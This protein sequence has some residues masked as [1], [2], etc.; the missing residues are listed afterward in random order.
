MN[1][2]FYMPRPGKKGARLLATAVPM[3]RHESLEVF[4]DLASFT[5]RVKKPKDPTSVAIIFDPTDDEL[6]SL[7]TLRGYL[8]GTKI[9][10]VLSGQGAETISLAHKLL[11]TYISYVD[12]DISRIGAVLKQT[13]KDRAENA[14]LVI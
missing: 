8:K 6:R 13:V 4:P 5:E 14:E 11:P 12:N 10:L 7:A 2:L 9:L 1:L 3:I